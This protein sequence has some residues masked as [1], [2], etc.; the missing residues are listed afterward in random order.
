MATANVRDVAAL[1]GVSVGTVSNV[2]NRSKRVS[3]DTA[4]RVLD[5]IEKLGF[6]RNDAARQLRV[7][8]SRTVGIMVLD[9]S[10]PFFTDIARGVEDTLAQFSRSL[11]LGN[12]GEDA[13]RELAYLDLFE[14]QRVAGLLITPVGD[15]HARL[16]RLRERG[17]PVVLV[18]RH[19]NARAF[20][21][22]SVDDNRG[23]YLAASHLLD[24]GRRNIAFVGGP[25]R[26]LQVAQRAGGAQD[27]VA[28]RGARPLHVL[29][30]DSMRADA[31]RLGAEQLLE[32]PAHERPDAVF[33]ANDLI[34][35]GVLR[36]LTHAGL[37]VPDDI[38]IIGY[39]DIYFAANAAI[40]ISSIRQPSWE[41]G[42]TATELLMAEI[43]EPTKHD[44]RHVVFQP[45]LIVRESTAG[46][47]A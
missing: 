39:D 22:V 43:E 18:D 13:A 1:A 3:P 27:A 34:A 24:L 40:P 20:S 9:V 29:E 35:L 15:V 19:E 23:G 17:S 46:A 44:Y 28:E 25:K 30:L 14:E 36:A 5:A 41:M 6:I 7:G 10:N 21:S 42:R 2:L 11:V 33:A 45:E 26:V 4:Q 31:G 16:E 32:L 8:Q 37:R 38:A 12:S 47:L